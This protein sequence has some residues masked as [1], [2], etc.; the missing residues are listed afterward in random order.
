M[1]S[2]VMSLTETNE[3]KNK[4]WST[5]RFYFCSFLYILSAGFILDIQSNLHFFLWTWREWSHHFSTK[6]NNKIMILIVT[7]VFCIANLI[8][9]NFPTNIP[10]L[11]NY[12]LNSAVS[13]KKIG[14]LYSGRYQYSTHWISMW[15]ATLYLCNKRIVANNRIP[16]SIGWHRCIFKKQHN[17]HMNRMILLR[18]N[19]RKV[20]LLRE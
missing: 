11:S 8:W 9:S 5:F 6:H 13:S 20:C 16:L 19:W 12:D 2:F 7:T 15:Y 3:T 4:I 14:S 18:L 1:I 17:D 10:I